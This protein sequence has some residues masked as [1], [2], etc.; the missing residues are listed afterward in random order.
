M[1][2]FIE[3]SWPKR[4]AMVFAAAVCLTVTMTSK[5]ADAQ[6]SVQ[7]PFVSLGV[8]VPAYYPYYYGYPYYY[9]AHLLGWAAMPLVLQSL[10]LLLDLGR[11]P[12]RVRAWRRSRSPLSWN[13]NQLALMGAGNADHRDVR[14]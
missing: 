13:P 11:G 6:I 1:T 12:R 4:C 2:R 5:P 3:G 9:R 14:W 10:S 8:G 7:L